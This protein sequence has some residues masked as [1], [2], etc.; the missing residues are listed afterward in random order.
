MA[1]IVSEQQL[2]FV[3]SYLEDGSSSLVLGFVC[4]CKVIRF[5]I[6]SREWTTS[7][8]LDIAVGWL[9]STIYEHPCIVL[10]ICVLSQG[11]SR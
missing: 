3:N 10:I 4:D 7:L 9:N 8:I 11:K 1:K 2:M 6:Q 5:Q